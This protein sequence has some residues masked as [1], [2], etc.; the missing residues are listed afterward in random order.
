M[1]PGSMIAHAR[2]ASAALPYPDLPDSTISILEKAL[3]IAWREACADEGRIGIDFQT[4]DEDDIS[5]AVVEVIDALCSDHKNRPFAA[6]S[7][8]FEVGIR[9]SPVATK[10]APR[11][12]D[13]EEVSG[14]KEK[15]WRKR[16]KPDFAFWPKL[17]PAGYNRLWYAI[18]IEAK[19]LEH[20]G[21]T[22][23]EYSRNGLSRFTEGK[24]AWSMTQ[25]FMLAFRRRNEQELPGSLHE[26]LDRRRQKFGV[27]DMPA[28]CKFSRSE[29][30]MHETRHRRDVVYTDTQKPLDPIRI[31]HLWLTVPA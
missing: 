1:K 18:F 17:L 26:N 13:E 23:G 15:R 30:R 6:F 31:F 27:I 5:D 22:V 21:K 7:E 24:Y 10:V 3:R 9:E 28:A 16:K 2:E 29:M 14:V 20:K 11:I 4:C 19:M 12:S 25:G 8:F